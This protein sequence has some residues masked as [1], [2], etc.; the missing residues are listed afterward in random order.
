M[1]SK[2]SVRAWMRLHCL[3][4]RDAGTDEIDYTRLVEACAREFGED[5]EG[6]PLDD[7]GHWIWDLAIEVDNAQEGRA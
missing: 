1:L 7:E 6:G 5:Y 2:K 3:Q 4:Y